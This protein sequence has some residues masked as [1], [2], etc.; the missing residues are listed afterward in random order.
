MQ[1]APILVAD[2]AVASL[3]D[4]QALFDAGALSGVAVKAPR[5]GGMTQ[6]ATL[7]RWCVDNGLEA[8]PGGMLECGLGRHALVALAAMEGMTIIGDVSPAG[9]W[10]AA[11]PWPDLQLKDGSVLVPQGPGV[12]PVPDAELLDEFT[13]EALDVSSRADL[14]WVGLPDLKATG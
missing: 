8:T 10:L 12:S 11:D 2:E 3:A 6:A 7:V 9:R 13:L 5:V 14:A 4:A 1:T